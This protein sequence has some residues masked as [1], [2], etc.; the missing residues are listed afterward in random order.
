MR[1]ALYAKCESPS[2]GPQALIN[3]LL[4]FT[5]KAVLLTL[6]A[7]LLSTNVLERLMMCRSLCVPQ[8]LQLSKNTRETNADASSKAT[9]DKYG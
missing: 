3:L 4:A 5:A 2:P 7:C 1:L 8:H 9:R 6:R